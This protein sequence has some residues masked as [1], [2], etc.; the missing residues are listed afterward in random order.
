MLSESLIQLSVDGWSSVPSLLFTWDQ[1]MVEVMKIMVS[2]SKDPMHTSPQSLPPAPQRDTMDSCLRRRLLDTP[3]K[4][5]S[6]SC[7]VTAPFSWILVHKSFCFYPPRVY[8]LVLCKF[9]QLYGGLN[10]DLLQ[11]GLCHT[12]VCCPQSPCPSDNPLL[13]HTSTGDAQTQFCLSLFG[14]PGSW[15]ARGLFEPSEHL[16]WEWVLILN[17]NSTLLPSHWASPLLLGV[18]CLLMACPVQCSHCSSAYHL[19]GLS[20]TLDVGCLLMA[21]PV[22]HKHC[23]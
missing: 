13:T 20:L 14:V 18:G 5:G 17:R 23:S 19:A 10:G 22:K 3:S 4:S 8:F 9:W 1:T 2:P 15:C 7:W 16:W 6:V 21:A 11:E 12:Q